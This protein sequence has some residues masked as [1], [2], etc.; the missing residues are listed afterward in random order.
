MQK[1]LYRNKPVSE[2]ILFETVNI[3]KTFFPD[4]LGDLRRRN[5]LLGKNVRIDPGHQN[6]FVV[7]TIKNANMASARHVVMVAPH[8]VVVQFF[9]RWLFERLYAAALRA[10][11]RHHV[12]N[13]AVFAC[14]IARLENQ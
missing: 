4:V 13:C 6:F 7:G 1:K 14:R 11:A 5:F 9:V 10:E 3:L 12:F 8:K 2:Q